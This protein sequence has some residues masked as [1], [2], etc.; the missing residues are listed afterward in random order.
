[1]DIVLNAPLIDVK[2]ATF[3]LISK[4]LVNLF[5]DDTWS[6]ELT[7]LYVA[8]GEIVINRAVPNLSK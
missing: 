7:D 2:L 1:M 5:Q 8:H 6:W 4:T 3:R